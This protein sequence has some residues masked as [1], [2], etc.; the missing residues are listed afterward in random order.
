MDSRKK[1]I[2]TIKAGWAV[3]GSFIDEV[4]NEIQNSIKNL[5]KYKIDKKSILI[6]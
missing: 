1:I 6:F 5:G 2:E 4:I 3:F